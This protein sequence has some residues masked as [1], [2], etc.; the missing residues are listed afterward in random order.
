MHRTARVIIIAAI[1]GIGAFAL[2]DAFA[3]SERGRLLYENHCQFCHESQ[4]HIREHRGAASP[5]ELRGFIQR[6]AAEL[7][8]T[9][10]EAEVNDVFQFLN[11]GYY[12]FPQ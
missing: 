10:G 2:P 8:L 12:K 1:F 3:D 9:W 7:K 11:N 4:V 6:W 5:A